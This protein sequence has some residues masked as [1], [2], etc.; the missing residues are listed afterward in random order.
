MSDAENGAPKKYVKNSDGLL[1]LNPDYKDWKNEAKEL[2]V[3]IGTPVVAAA[4][5]TATA[6]SSSSL[7]GTTGFLATS[8]NDTGRVKEF[9]VKQ[10]FH[11]LAA[12]FTI[13]SEHDGNKPYRVKGDKF[14]WGNEASFQLADGTQIAYIKETFSS[15]FS[16]KKTYEIYKGAAT[17]GDD[18][19]AKPWVRTFLLKKTTKSKC[20]NIYDVS[21]TVLLLFV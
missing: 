6:V 14:K 19:N 15:T 16:M 10:K 4:T 13:K 20:S 18:E 5:A 21:I 9:H 17:N 2:P 7:S 11:L 12:N 3:A 1:E 8:L